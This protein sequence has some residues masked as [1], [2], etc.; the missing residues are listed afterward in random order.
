MPAPPT[1]TTSLFF[2][3]GL[4][5]QLTVLCG[6]IEGS[7]CSWPP[8]PS[9]TDADGDG[10]IIRPS[11]EIT[12]RLKLFRSTPNAQAGAPFRL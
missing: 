4:S 3:L 7:V 5:L 9:P 1:T 8:P 11:P 10:E 6:R 2:T 12:E